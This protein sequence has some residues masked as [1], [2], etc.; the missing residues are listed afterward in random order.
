MTRTLKITLTMG[1][2]LSLFSI[3]ACS[4]A[5]NEKTPDYTSERS[6]VDPITHIV[7]QADLIALG[8]I[9]D[10]RNEFTTVVSD[11]S[12]RKYTNTYFTFSIEKV[13]KGDPS[14]NE[15]II[16][17]FFCGRLD[18][19]TYQWSTACAGFQI[20]DHVLL[21]LMRNEDYY[22]LYAAPYP[23]GSIPI[24]D[25]NSDFWWDRSSGNPLLAR[26]AQE[27]LEQIMGR[28]YRILIIYNVPYNMDEPV[29]IP[30][31]EP[32]SPPKN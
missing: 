22:Y 8:K 20:Y 31:Y 7:L 19:G 12:T 32:A 23:D 5:V 27:A 28:I 18:D 25:T 2:L 1:L 16:K 17:Q 11:N 13:L 30:I 21:G 3:G 9:T 26:E 10:S 24:D 15:V 6:Y 4:G 29:P 14:I